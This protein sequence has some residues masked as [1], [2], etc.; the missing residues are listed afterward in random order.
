MP[1]SDDDRRR[2]V[3]LVVHDLRNPLAALMGNL[4]LLREEL[5]DASAFVREG[6]D[7]CQEL[8][9]RALT[10][11]ATI[12]DVNELEAGDLQV[13]LEEIEVDELV[14][15]AV[16]RNGAGVRVRGLRVEVDVA[17]Q[18]R[19]M[20]D[21]GLAERVLEHLFDNAVRYARRG[22]RVVVSA[23]RVDGDV[24]LAVGND[25]PPVPEKEREAI[26]GRTYRAEARRA[27]AHRGLG[28]YFCKLAVEA[29]G[30]S[31][32]VETRG[33]LGA[34]FVARIPQTH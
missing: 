10:L 11:V 26:F 18:L 22:G 28:L 31:I 24:E 13:E 1:A 9:T 12:L 20:L 3:E 25:G 17:P 7:G 6:L 34:V 2:L 19:A 4:E 14:Q 32:N 15:Q 16:G 33:D 21:R 23:A 30:G 27:T 5:A 29:H 8:A